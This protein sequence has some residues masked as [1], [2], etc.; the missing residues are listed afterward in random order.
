MGLVVCGLVQPPAPPQ[1]HQV[2]DAPTASQWSGRGDLPSPGCRLRT[3]A[4]AKP[5]PVVAIDAL[6]AST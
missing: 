4:P 3:S 6:L 5:T 1:R 2:R